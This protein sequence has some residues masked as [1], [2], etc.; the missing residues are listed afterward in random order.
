MFFIIFGGRFKRKK[1]LRTPG[2]DRT[3]DSGGWLHEKIEKNPETGDVLSSEYSGA[4]RLL[5]EA[6]EKIKEITGRE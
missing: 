5:R 4:A 1:Y 2:G 3:D 6:R